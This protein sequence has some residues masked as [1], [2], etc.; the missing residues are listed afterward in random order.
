MIVVIGMDT[1]NNICTT[2]K[3]AKACR[4][5]LNK[6]HEE[7]AFAQE[8]D[9]HFFNYKTAKALLWNAPMQKFTRSALIG[10]KMAP[11]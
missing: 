11:W 2:N 3:R 5:V 9:A 6:I 7:D 4:S 10:L 8:R 1:I